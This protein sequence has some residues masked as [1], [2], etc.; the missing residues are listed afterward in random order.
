MNWLVKST[1]SMRWRKLMPRRS[2]ASGKVVRWSV[3]TQTAHAASDLIRPWIAPPVGP[4]ISPPLNAERKPPISWLA[5]DATSGALKRSW[6]TRP[7]LG[8]CLQAGWKRWTKAY[9]RDSPLNELA[10]SKPSDVMSRYSISATND[11]STHVA[12]G[13]LMG[14]VSLDFGLTT[15]SSCLRI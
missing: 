2:R 1:G 7:L 10:R 14:L 6:R 12:L 15:V 11:G 4:K 13:F 8:C 5:P 3:L 9:F